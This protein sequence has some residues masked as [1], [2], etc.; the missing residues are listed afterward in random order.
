MVRA[1]EDI[2][3]P[4]LY[5][6]SSTITN[7]P[8]QLYAAQIPRS[9]SCSP[10]RNPFRGYNKV[11]HAEDVMRQSLFTSII[12]V[13]FLVTACKPRSEVTPTPYDGGQIQPPAAAIQARVLLAN[14]LGIQADQ[15]TISKI[16]SAQWSDACL[17]A[18]AAEEICAQ[19][20]VDGYLVEMT[21]DNKIYTFHTDSSGAQIRE[22]QEEPEY[23][24]AAMQSRQL[25]AA[26]LGYDP[27]S[28]QI[29]GDEQVRFADSCLEISIPE[30]ICSQVKVLGHRVTMLAE[31]D[32]FEFRS[33]SDTIN[34]VLAVAAGI[35]AGRP[36]LMMSRNGGPDKHC[37]NIKVTLS[38]DLIL[39]ACEGVSGTTPGIIVLSA[40]DQAQLLKWVL[41]FASFDITQTKLDGEK[42]H[43]TF[44]GT[45][46]DFAQYEDQQAIQTFG[47]S[48]FREPQLLPS[49]LPTAN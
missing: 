17:E 47:E 49:P 9:V 21:F 14:R 27:E 4:T 10:E 2:I 34:P 12:L 16:E 32:T 31:G 7:K 8:I 24:M 30:T 40:Q 48:L 39:Y 41:E 3:T 46:R 19:I 44:E 37:D 13:L 11:N 1:T 36:V 20:V 15:I 18:G 26:M 23:S 33:P 43:L 42:V 22:V 38:G 6:K 35:P 29:T 25:L 28:I 45:G 5:W